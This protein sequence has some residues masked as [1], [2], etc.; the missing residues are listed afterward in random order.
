MKRLE[1]ERVWPWT[2]YNSIPINGIVHITLEVLMQKLKL[3]N[4]IFPAKALQY[5]MDIC[6]VK[7]FNVATF[8]ICLTLASYYL[9]KNSD[10]IQLV[11]LVS[12]FI[13]S[14]STESA[15]LTVNELHQ[16]SNHC[17]TN[18]GTESEIQKFFNAK[19]RFQ[20]QFNTTFL[21]MEFQISTLKK[22]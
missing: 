6:R 2:Q 22:Y 18:N 14:K 20:N 12:L 8:Q 17:F 3:T 13:A 5:V 9:M 1:D 16:C 19:T 4:F 7:K 11:L 21:L 10:H 15:F